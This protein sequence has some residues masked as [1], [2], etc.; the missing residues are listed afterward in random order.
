FAHHKVGALVKFAADKGKPLNAL[1]LKEMKSVFPEADSSM[2]KLFS[3]AH[4]VE[5]RDVYG[6][7]GFKQVASQVAFWKKELRIP[8]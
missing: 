4:A 1:T 5:G 7:T 6:A 2:L 3:P 8:S